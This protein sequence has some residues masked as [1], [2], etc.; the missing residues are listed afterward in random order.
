MNKNLFS[1]PQ[2]HLAPADTRNNAGGL[3]YAMSAEAGL[4]Q[5]AC[6]GTFGDTFYVTA[7]KQ[8]EKIL[9][10]LPKCRPEFVA[11]AAV[12]GRK[13][14]FMKD[15]PA[16]IAAW[17]TVRAKEDP[18]TWGEL[19]EAAFHGVVDN[20]KMLRNY[21]QA[22]R[23]GQ[24]GPRGKHL[25]SRARKLITG[26]LRNAQPRTVINAT[27][28]NEPS[29]A[30]VIRLTRPKPRDLRE[31]ALWGWVVD[32]E[33]AE[34]RE[35]RRNCWTPDKQAALPAEVA[36]LE[37]WR[38]G[39][40]DEQPNVEF[41]LLTGT[42]LPDEVWANIA[43]NAPWQMT[44]MN[45]NTFARHGVFKDSSI[46]RIVA[47]RLRDPAAIARAKVFP[48][49]LLVAYLNVDSTIPMEIQNALQDAL[50]VSLDNVPILPGRTV[51]IVDTSGSMQSAVTGMRGTATSKV[52]CIDV[53][54]LFAASA[55]RRNP[56]YTLILPVD[57]QVHPVR[58]NPR[59]TVMTNAR[60]LAGFGGGGT[61]LASAFAW[62]TDN[63]V[64][65]EQVVMI[66][67][68]ESWADRVSYWQRQGYMSKVPATPMA[69]AIDTWRRQTGSTNAKLI[70]NDITPN[71]TT[72]EASGPL[73]LNIGGFG[74]EV[75]RMVAD[76]VEG[77]HGPEYWID[78]V[79]QSFG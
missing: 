13:Q 72:P 63:G 29:L 36:Q 12:Y 26:W 71:T 19:A 46:V 25:G 53:A 75:W 74:D 31:A 39:L 58:L 61:A 1:T 27:V 7:D 38:K 66:S 5:I 56:D 78:R 20:G 77:R 45:L 76:F 64:G 24:L 37:E 55:M 44:R 30:D 60:L 67:D 4:A 49:Q 54:A 73:V 22:L 43:R 70:F 23:S 2:R 47:D 10:L 42:E 69:S 52:R 34:S 32:A 62:M 11:A 35:G 17:M 51:V 65:A 79:L 40:T 8:L 14:G 18:A 9:D 48:Y 6:T 21:V 57:T 28:G 16:V 3:A 59:D 15:A 50:E 41:R 68:N 33:R